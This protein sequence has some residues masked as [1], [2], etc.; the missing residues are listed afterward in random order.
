[1]A[2][3]HQQMQEMIRR[4]REE[5]GN[6]AVD[7]HE[8]AAWAVKRYGWKL[9][10]P[11]SPLDRLAKEFSAAA[12]EEIRKDAVTGQPYRANHAVPIRKPS[13]QMSFVW[14]DI[15]TAPRRPMF[16]SLMQRRE[17]M[18]G[19]AFQLTL[20]AD[21]WNRIHPIE[22]PIQLPLDFTDDVEWRKNAA[23]DD[24]DAA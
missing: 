4:Y 14:V 16:K 13:G 12:R 24:D 22:E 18:V 19:D 15:D 21:H 20:D 7:M 9:P 6:E 8:V 10:D 1:M 5:T 17:Q 23:D 2:T 3:R 11:V